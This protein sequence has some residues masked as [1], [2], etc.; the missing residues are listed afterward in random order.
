MK[1]ALFCA[2]RASHFTYFHQPYFSELSNLGWEIHTVCQGKHTI[3]SVKKNFE[4]KFY[5]QTNLV[6]NLV[7]AYKLAKII[8]FER[9]D[10]VVSNS[11]LAG[12]IC[13][14]ALK[15]SHSRDYRYVHIAHGYLFKIDGG[16]KTKI[17]L[18][19]E[20]LFLSDKDRVLVMNKDDLDIIGRYRITDNYSY[21]NG[22]GLRR[23]LFPDILVEKNPNKFRFLCVAE[24]S[25]RK[26]QLLI[27]KAFS[28]LIHKNV[29]AEL[30]FAG[31]GVKMEKCKRLA[32][33][34]NL[35]EHITF[36]GRVQDMNRLYRNCDVLISASQSEGLPFNIMESL[37]C[38]TP[39]IASNVKGNNDLIRDGLNGRL[40]ELSNIDSL[41]EIMVKLSCDMYY[42]RFIKENTCLNE[43]YFVEN[44]KDEILEEYEV[45]TLSERNG[46]VYEK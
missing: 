23:E 1:K 32:D 30:V 44:I 19:F 11:T 20:K 28:Q 7:T 38:G 6:A 21:I 25:K 12:I 36:C 46:Y 35:S 18:F 31:D 9:Y 3:E 42:Y 37:Y 39:V 5:K 14:I 26:N 17:C 27:I 33:E 45:E 43:K 13:R 15:L 16:I 22:M 24:F 34:L 8:A 41:V 4:L 40:F 10:L 29:N 2:S